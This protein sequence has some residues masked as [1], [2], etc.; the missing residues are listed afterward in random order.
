[1]TPQ[2]AAANQRPYEFY[3][4]SEREQRV[5]AATMDKVK[6]DEPAR[7]AREAQ[8]NERL[9]FAEG[10]HWVQNAT[11]LSRIPESQ[12]D[13][14]VYPITV[15]FL[16]AAI[17]KFVSRQTENPPRPEV[18]ARKQ[19]RRDIE[20]ARCAEKLLTSY[21]E[22]K[23]ELAELRH[24]LWREL[25]IL[26][27]TFRGVLWDK[28]AGDERPLPA[29]DDDG[30]YRIDANRGNQ[31]GVGYVPWQDPDTGEPKM[32]KTGEPVDEI[33]S[34]FEFIPSPG[35]T[36]MKDLRWLIRR[37]PKPLSW[38]RQQ[39]PEKGKYV[40]PESI[41]FDAQK[42]AAGGTAYM[43]VTAPERESTEL[44]PGDKSEEDRLDM[45]VVHE[46]WE[47]P[48]P[49][50]PRGYVRVNTKEIL[51]HEGENPYGEIPYLKYDDI[52]RPGLF[53]SGSR[54]EQTIAPQREIN[55]IFTQCVE[56][57]DAVGHPLVVT[58]ANSVD[59]EDIAQ[60]PVTHLRIQRGFR[61]PQIVMGQA[62]PN[63]AW[64]L[65]NE[66][67][68]AIEETWAWHEPSRGI[69][70]SNIQSGRMSISLQQADDRSLADSSRRVER[71]EEKHYRMLLSRLRQ[72]TT[73]ERQVEIIG[74]DHIHE[75]ISFD[76]E[77]W[78]MVEV[79]IIEGS[80]APE[81]R[82]D[83]EQKVFGY[84]QAGL[85]IDPRTGMPDIRQALKLLGQGVPAQL[86]LT[87]D[88]SEVHANREL[89]RWL[90][91][92]KPLAVID[93]IET[94]KE[95][96]NVW[97][98]IVGPLDNDTVHLR[99]IFDFYES[100]EY[101]NLPEKFGPKIGRAMQEQVVWHAIAHQARIPAIQTAM[102]GSALSPAQATVP[103]PGG[104]GEQP[105]PQ[106]E[107]PTP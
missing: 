100:A 72:F 73:V 15:N 49:E 47:P 17:E 6:A 58:E 10:K 59:E 103:A 81:S 19:G 105:A 61:M 41:V 97:K 84:M 32:V 66:L 53:W 64:K 80:S 52:P 63:E 91:G 88:K 30:N 93:E 106:A 83:R 51:L 90:R 5:V 24:R 27:N 28:H 54:T 56:N 71:V 65:I 60:A 22:P 85:I 33:L 57:L 68:R 99:V 62:I 82:S 23:L 1:M 12:R 7:K 77:L 70:R 67:M 26:G 74:E 98:G 104:A 16:A 36:S 107:G 25:C 102:Q 20:R 92:E 37:Y 46:Y 18:V 94:E 45:A 8:W 69:A 76:Q 86:L 79:S 95:G 44:K 2:N 9:A 21:Y 34:P 29:R 75:A 78:E 31:W 55:A 50:Y 101:E 39:Y 35:S 13:E 89:G 14:G 40:R 43:G 4:P 42:R 87:Q 96:M 38:I 11:M 3:K 48:T